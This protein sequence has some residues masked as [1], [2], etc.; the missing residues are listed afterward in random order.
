MM[1][2]DALKVAMQAFFRARGNSSKCVEAAIDAYH[3][4]AW[5]NLIERF[6]PTVCMVDTEDGPALM[7]M[8]FKNEEELAL[9]V[10]ER[11][12]APRQ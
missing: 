12:N 6:R 4:A 2:P 10:R 8:G 3:C 7:L 9:Y 1:D 5:N 11:F